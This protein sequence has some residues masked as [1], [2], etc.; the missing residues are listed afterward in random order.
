MVAIDKPAV[1]SMPWNTAPNFRRPGQV[2]STDIVEVTPQ[3]WYDIVCG[4]TT[5]EGVS[6]VRGYPISARV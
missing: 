5:F 6:R 4:V 3:I 2:V 1:E